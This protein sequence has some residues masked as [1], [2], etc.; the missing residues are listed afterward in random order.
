MTE[1]LNYV[2]TSSVQKVLGQ[3]ISDLALNP[4]YT[5]GPST[6]MSSLPAYLQTNKV[7]IQQLG[8][9]RLAPFGKEYLGW[10]EPVMQRLYERFPTNQVQR[11]ELLEMYKNW[12]DPVLAAIATFVWGYID[13]RKDKR[14]QQVLMLN[15]SALKERL[16]RIHILVTA[17]EIEEA[18]LSCCTGNDNHIRGVG[19][20]FFTKLFFFIGESVSAVRIKPLILD[21]WT[22]NAFFALEAQS[23]GLKGARDWFS[24]PSKAVFEKSK[25]V[26]LKPNVNLQAAA[27]V[28]YINQMNIWASELNVSPAKLEEFVFGVH[29]RQNKSASNPRNEI[30]SIICGFLP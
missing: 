29:R 30:V 16:D 19:M 9:Q 13:T 24:L 15:E 22:T 4:K 3:Y 25:A 11:S 20:S 18:F 17:G 10:T 26:Y 12:E 5:K 23:L 2:G 7:R 6:R 21:R 28:R 8:P 1:L 14:L 27:Y